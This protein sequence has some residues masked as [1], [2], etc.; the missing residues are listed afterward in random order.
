MAQVTRDRQ[1]LMVG[2]QPPHGR[3]LPGFSS[4]VVPQKVFTPVGQT[5][6]KSAEGGCLVWHGNCCTPVQV[7]AA[8]PRKPSEL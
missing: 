4:V 8:K 3:P 7:A 1:T 2:Q 5:D 6:T